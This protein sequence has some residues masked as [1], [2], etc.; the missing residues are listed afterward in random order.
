M[1]GTR[2]FGTDGV[3]GEANVTLTPQ[4]AL[5]LGMA[6]GEFLRQ[7][8]L[9]AGPAKRLEV[10]IGRDTRL[11]GEMLQAALASGFASMGIDVV[12]VGIVPTPG[13]ARLVLLRQAVAGAVISASHNPYHD[14]GIKFLGSNGK[15]LPDAVE[16]TIAAHIPLLE[17]LPRVKGAEIGRIRP[18]TSLAEAYARCVKETIRPLG[19]K[20]LTG[21]KLVLDCANGATYAL[22]PHIFS[23]L[24]AEVVVLNAN[25]DGVNINWECGSTHPEPLAKATKQHKAHAGLAFDG[26][27]DRVIM[28]D[29]QG[30]TVDGDR[31]MAILALQMAREERLPGRVVVATIMSNVGLEQALEREGIRLHRTDVG[32]RYV[33]EA[34]EALGAGIGGEQSG[35]I[36]LPHLSP[37]G[38][39][40]ITGLQVLSIMVQ[41]GKPLS[42]LA[43]VVQTCPQVLR[44]V[45]VQDRQAWRNDTVVQQAIERAR[46][47]LGRAEWLSVRASGTEPL[48]RVMAQGTDA[49]LVQSV[50][51]EICALIETR[52]GLS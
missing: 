20:P 42:E 51:E 32:D 6:A 21:L 36:L 52:C 38:D 41:T 25:P 49:A 17:S 12:D 7:Q 14:N 45:R 44:N 16:D 18:D 43:G 29:E 22:A 11:S 40:M 5:H 27:A 13:V 8:A 46:E 15:K 19:S 24:G 37:A 31:I 10:L 34:M 9:S 50:V 35:H 39:G 30:G 1:S 26:D 3:R 2:L 28:A 4:L 23:D 47:R 33:A 48:V